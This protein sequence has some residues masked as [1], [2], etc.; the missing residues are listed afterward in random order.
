[1]IKYF[2]GYKVPE[3]L[4]RTVTAICTRF[5]ISGKCDPMYI[6][7]TIA[8]VSGFGDGRGHFEQGGIINPAK[9]AERVQSAYGCNIQRSETKE[10]EKIISTG[11]IDKTKAIQRLKAFR[12]RAL[13]EMKTCDPWRVDYL[14]YLCGVIDRSI[15]AIIGNRMF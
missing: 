15:N 12:Q 1:M 3:E 2:D 4:K 8:V 9:A 14:E 11:I 6:A 5:A 10:L 7:N 13:Q